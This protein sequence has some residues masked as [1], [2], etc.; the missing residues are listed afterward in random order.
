MTTQKRWV[1]VG[2]HSGSPGLAASRLRRRA[3][4]GR[5]SL[6]VIVLTTIGLL[7]SA[8]VA[9]AKDAS[10]KNQSIGPSGLHL[11]ESFEGLELTGY[12]LGDGMCTIGYGHAVPL[13]EISTAD[14][15]NWTITQAE[16]EGFLK[17]DTERFSDAVNT[18]FTRS[19]TQCQFDALVS[20]AY[21]VGYAW[22][23]YDW[24]TSPEDSYFPGV[25]IQ[26]TNPPQ[27]K[28][29]LLRRRQAEI[30]V[31]NS[32]NCEIPGSTSS[33]S[34]SGT[35]GSSSEE[36]G[37]SWWGITTSHETPA[38]TTDVTQPIEV[39]EFPAIP[40]LFKGGIGA[41]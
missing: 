9:D 25:M 33:S 20:F 23:K 29:G 8:L 21:N 31:F 5:T 39:I 15:K 32:T 30:D 10:G 40:P 34:S 36:T 22:Q 19:F 14:C 26:Y 41:R 38:A 7:G 35:S 17:E 13:T 16:A 1:S 18:Y 3:P 24:S 2:S 28:A 11:I 27:F 37:S 6:A 12:V 4:K